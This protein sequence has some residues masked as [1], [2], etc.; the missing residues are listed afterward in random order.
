MLS[1]FT[2]KEVYDS[3]KRTLDEALK[4]KQEISESYKGVYG[5]NPAPFR[6]CGTVP[7]PNY[8][9]GG[10]TRQDEWS[11][12]MKEFFDLR[13]LSGTKGNSPLP[14]VEIY[15][16]PPEPR[17]RVLETDS[18]GRKEYPMARGLLDYFPDALAE[19]AKVSFLGNQ[20]HNPG[21]EMHHARGKSNDHADCILRHLAGRGGWD[22]ASRE[23][24][25]LAWRALAL[26]QEELER[27]LNLPLPRGARE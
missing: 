21:Q 26:L 23:S 24:A 3:T 15:A 10:I 11:K 20:K 9:A 27:D 14:L 18:A 1:D 12:P 8:I 17:K 5:S 6:D 4:R 16:P 7:N 19:V 2:E 13:S 25:Q 22:G